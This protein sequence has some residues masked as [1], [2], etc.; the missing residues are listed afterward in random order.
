M[1]F[2]SSAYQILN[3]Y[4][5]TQLDFISQATDLKIKDCFTD[6][7]LDEPG[8]SMT[9]HLDNPG[10]TNSMQIYLSEDW[11]TLGT[12]FY[13]SNNRQRFQVPY[14]FNCGYIMKNGPEQYHG[15]PTVVPAGSHRL[16]SYTHLKE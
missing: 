6:I 16:H 10:V 3:N 12:C 11:L 7:W 5:H 4:I 8:F 2:R 13:D 15:A 14:L 9:P 1:L